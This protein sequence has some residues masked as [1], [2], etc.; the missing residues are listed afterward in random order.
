MKNWLQTRLNWLD[1]QNR[2]GSVIYR[3][4]AFSHYGG[5]VETGLELTMSRHTGT[6]PSGTSYANGTIYYTLDGT[7]PRSG[8]GA[9]ST[10]AQSYAEPVILNSSAQVTARLYNSGAWSPATSAVFVVN[11]TAANATN[12]VVS[13]LHYNPSGPTA[14]EA[15]AGFNSAN[16]FEYIELLNVGTQ[17]VDLSG[18]TIEDAVQFSFTAADPATLTLLPGARVVIAENKDAFLF[19]YGTNPAVKV[20]GA[21]SGNLSN[22]GEQI[23]VRAADT[24]VI[25]QFAWGEAEPWPVAAD[26]EGYSLVLNSPAASPAYGSGP[27]WRSSA[28]RGGRPGLPD[29]TPFAGSAA[30]DTDLDGH[31]DYLEYATGS[32]PADARSIHRPEVDIAPFVIEGTAADYLRF[33]YRRNLAADGCTYAVLLSEDSLT[34]QGG[35][36]AVTYVGTVHNGDGTATVTYRSTDPHSPSRSKAFMRLRVSP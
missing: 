4:P 19:R 9:L 7:D 1:D 31:S 6:P 30:G 3:P 32:D 17:S 25:A 29:S 12:L 22:S 26:G 11:A 5:N 34:W 33:Q 28:D 2:V 8:T 10:A 24:S 36:G 13:E 15:A 21:F 20:A 18:V 27:S 14:A 35:T 16:D 23:I